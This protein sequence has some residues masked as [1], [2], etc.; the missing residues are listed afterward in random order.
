MNEQEKAESYRALYRVRP[1]I[2]HIGDIRLWM[3]IRQD[4]VVMWL[5]YLFVFFI[6]CYILPVLTVLPFDRAITMTVGPVAAAYYTVKLDPA[7]KTV[8]RYLRDIVH[9]LVRPKWVVRWQ[10]VRQP[11]G[12]HRVR[13]IGHC[14][15]YERLPLQQGGEEWC[16]R[17]GQLVG[18]VEGFRVLF[19]PALVR[20]RWMVRS[21]R[22]SIMP[23][24][25]QPKQAVVPPTWLEGHRVLYG[26]AA[27]PLQ[28]ER[29]FKEKGKEHWKAQ[30]R[31][32]NHAR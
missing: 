14:R 9:F 2:Y 16:G 15:P 31:A 3:P 20:M 6:F 25:R 30:V 19:L 1:L 7:G 23:L 18:T 21:G 24:K 10:A 29:E 8:P 22:L 17:K 11:G 27:T 28:L 5:V 13:F 26:S 32:D 12:T 4:G